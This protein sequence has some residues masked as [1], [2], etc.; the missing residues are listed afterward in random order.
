MASLHLGEL[1]RDRARAHPGREFVVSGSSRLTYGQV[2]ER[3]TRLA[4]ALLDL[5]LKPGQ[6][7]AIA[8]RNVPEW[9]VAALAGARLGLTLVPLDPGLS[10]HELKYQ[11]R[12][13]EAN[14][15]VVP[16]TA[17]GRDFLELF[18]EMLPDLPELAA[19]ISVGAEERWYEDRVYRF[20]DMVAKGGQRELPSSL[21]DPARLPLAILYTSGTMGKPKGV[22]LAHRTIIDAMRRTGEGA[23]LGEAE[24]VLA[25][26][27]GFHVFGFGV[28][29]GTIAL[30]GTLILQERFE[31]GAALELIARERVSV[32]HGV[33]TMFELLMRHPDF[34]AADSAPSG[35]ESWAA[36]E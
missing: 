21:G 31:A 19:L 7:L 22:V 27:P 30:G 18:D 35:P 16:E 25:A 1:F 3:A 2:D 36:A 4:R 23:A 29:V 26:V 8:L 6:R 12:Q 11:L 9:F 34:G 10:F 14:A 32:V 28:A 15:V 13:S 17:G 33:P 20:E 5:G 24:R